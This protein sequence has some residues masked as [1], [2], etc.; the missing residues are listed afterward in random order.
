MKT[1]VMGFMILQVRFILGL[2]WEKVDA[3]IEPSEIKD[4]TSSFVCVL[5]CYSDFTELFADKE[6]PILNYFS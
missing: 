3:C 5:D 4:I 2:F 1:F 6:Q